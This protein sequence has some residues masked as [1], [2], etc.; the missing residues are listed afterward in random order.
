MEKIGHFFRAILRFLV[1]W[2]VDT[3]SILVTA[4]V[5]SGIT[6]QAVQSQGSFIVATAA[7]LLLGIINFL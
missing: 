7:A 2:F 6:I 1:V 5:V 4:W 3:I